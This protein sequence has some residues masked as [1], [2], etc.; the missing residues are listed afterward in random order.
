MLVS[1]AP[2]VGKTALVDQLRPVIT[3]ADGWWVAGKFDQYRRDL[4]FDGVA[5][6]FRALGR[7]LLA[8][9]EDE[10]TGVRT[11]LLASARAE[12]RAGDCLTPEFA[13]LL[14]VPPDAGD[15][16]TAQAR[17]QRNVVQILRAVASRRRPVVVFVDDLQWAGRTPLGVVDLL[18]S[19]DP[20]EGLLLVG[21]YRE[22]DVDATHPLAGLLSRWREQA[23]VRLPA[24]G[25]SARAG[26]GRPGRGDA[27]HGSG[28]GRAWP[29]CSARTPPAT[30]T[31]PWSCS[32]R[33]AV[34]GC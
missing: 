3:G 25:Q 34:P 23:G 2:G 5:Q 33:C 26:P 20:V 19:E 10:L 31:R 16:L 12:R 4:E 9:P 21:A 7:L 30:P 15:P 1:G 28:R 6:A 27:A 32:T 13:A 17:V 22:D 18:L 29:G 8:E 11:R 24:A 14:R